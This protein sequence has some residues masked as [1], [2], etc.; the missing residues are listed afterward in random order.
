MDS[1]KAWQTI[2]ASPDEMHAAF[3]AFGELPK[4][5][6]LPRLIMARRAVA[7]GYYTD[8]LGLAPSTDQ[9][10]LPSAA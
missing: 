7:A 10:D 6:I 2:N 5:D 3:T 8:T 1:R 9:W 4:M